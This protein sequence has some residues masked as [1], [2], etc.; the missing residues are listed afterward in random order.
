M[1]QKL[2]VVL[3]AAALAVAV[4]GST[5]LSTAAGGA[6]R[7]ALFA[8]NADKV[9]GIHASRAPRAGRLLPLGKNGRFPIS[10][11]PRGLAGQTGPP[12][13]RGPVGP[14]GAKG[15]PGPRGPDRKSVV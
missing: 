2:P 1:G 10:V 5:P 13:P 4:L 3:S 9:D 11:L 12:G 8:R 14:A 7:K 15:D 6:V